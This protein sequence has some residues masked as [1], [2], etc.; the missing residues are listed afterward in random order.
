MLFQTIEVP[1][2]SYDELYLVRTQNSMFHA[3][4]EFRQP[5]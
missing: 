3:E 4:S 5:K 1:Y 2:V